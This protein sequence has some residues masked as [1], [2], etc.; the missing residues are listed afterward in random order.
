M[1]VIGNSTSIT[2]D[3]NRRCSGKPA[4]L[5]TL[6]IAAVLAE[7]LG[8]E[9]LEPIRPGDRRQ[10]L[11]QQRGDALPL[12][13][14]VDHERHLGVVA[15]LPALVARPGD[16]LAVFLHHQRHTIDVVDVGEA[17]ELGVGQRGLGVKYRL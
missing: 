16:E 6:N 1:S 17:L 7:R 14:V 4:R 15:V 2:P 11:E 13:P 9:A 3:S 12:M 5:N 8:R 10:V